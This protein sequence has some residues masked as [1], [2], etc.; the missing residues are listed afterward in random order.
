M[1]VWLTIGD[2]LRG[3]IVGDLLRRADAADAAAIDLDVADLAVVDQMARHV[4]I[5][6]RL[7]AGEPHLAAASAAQRAIGLQSALAW[8]GSSSQVARAASRAG[9]RAAAALDVLAEDLAGIDQ[10]DA[11]RRRGL[12]AR[13]RNGRRRPS[14]VAAP[15]RTPAELGGAETL[16]ARTSRAALERL[17]RRVA[18]EQRGVGRLL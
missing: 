14:R 3:R 18:E 10:Q 4:D 5:V 6:R 16:R 12:R 9:S 7:A 17:L 15:D 8:N 11:V 1:K 2:A 13:Q